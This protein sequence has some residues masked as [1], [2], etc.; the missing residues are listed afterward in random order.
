[1][2]EHVVNLCMQSHDDAI[3]KNQSYNNTDRYS[4]P[5]TTRR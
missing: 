3:R 5:E 2:V 4:I 1:M